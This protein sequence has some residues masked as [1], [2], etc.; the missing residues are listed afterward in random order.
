MTIADIEEYKKAFA[1]SVKRAL[2]AG[3][4]VI[5]IHNAH[6]RFYSSLHIFRVTQNTQD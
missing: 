5:E 3:F 2:V 1:A 4:D 6:G